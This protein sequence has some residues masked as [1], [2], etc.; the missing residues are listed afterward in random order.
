MKKHCVELNQTGQFSQFFLDYLNEKEQLKPF[1][2]HSPKIESFKEAINAKNFSSGQRSTLVAS[3]R[4]QY[5]GLELGEITEA[6][7]ESLANEKTFTV[8]TGHQ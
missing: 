1:Y 2:A 3:L 4:S 6:N 7:I 8:T 5:K